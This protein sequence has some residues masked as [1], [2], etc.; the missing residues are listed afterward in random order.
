M[1]Q[2][3]GKGIILLL[4]ILVPITPI[5]T[6]SQTSPA[7]SN[8]LER[9][10]PILG[11]T[12]ISIEELQKILASLN[13]TSTDPELK[14]ILEN[15]NSSLQKGDYGGYEKAREQL[16]IYLQ[17]MMLRENAP[18]DMNTIEK[19]AL[20][21]STFIN[22]TN[23]SV[24][25]AKFAKIMSELSENK[26]SNPAGYES[27]L[28]QILNRTNSGEGSRQ[29]NP[30]K[31]PQ[32]PGISGKPSVNFSYGISL[33]DILKYTIL[34]GLLASSVYLLHRYKHYINTK[35]SFLAGKII[36]QYKYRRITPGTPREA[37][38]LCF[39]RLVD[40]LS[41]IGYTR[42]SWETPREYLGKIR[43]MPLVELRESI[44][45][46]IEK[47]KYSPREPTSKDSEKCQ[48]ILRR[49]EESEF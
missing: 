33:L 3:I 30:P 45:M 1:K 15:M 6:Y 4:L 23:G 8:E 14:Q 22:E 34:L 17:N 49:V 38:L 7:S 36:G 18:F 13:S 37:I 25:M 48:N 16:N 12:T 21:A 29:L 28:N 26:T 46:L 47:A 24:D 35:L 11:N 27:S 9:H 20:L 40:M 39:D 2:S 10:A 43:I 19:L 41:R 42:N 5:T 31:I 44:A 32:V